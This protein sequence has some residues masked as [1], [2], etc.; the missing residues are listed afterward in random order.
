MPRK[1]DPIIDVLRYFEDTE[2]VLAE[3]ALVLV[4]EIV[5]HRQPVVRKRVLKPKPQPSATAA[6]MPAGEARPLVERRP[7]PKRPP[8]K[9]ED[10][11]LPGMQPVV[12]G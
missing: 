1:K 7:P 10:R 11:P 6:T 3:Q 8:V 12:G 4:K 2:L 9:E 5:K